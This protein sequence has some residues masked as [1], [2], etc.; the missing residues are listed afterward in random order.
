MTRTAWAAA[1]MIAVGGCATLQNALQPP[2]FS[3]AEGRNA[4]L[5]LVGPSAQRPL[6]GAAIRLYARIENPNPL[7]LTLT[8][9]IGDVYLQDTRAAEVDFPLGVPLG[10]GEDT[11]IPLDVSISFSDLPSLAGVLRNAVGGRT[12]PYSLRGTF[13]VD[14]GPLGTPS[15]GPSTLM[16]GDVEVFR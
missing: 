8:R 7:G 16:R 2:R 9:L 15:F 10:A 11:V 12:V 3:A 1:A 6:G 13:S 5:R 14:A 4:E